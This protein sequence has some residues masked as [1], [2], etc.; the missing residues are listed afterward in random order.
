MNMADVSQ[1]RP[2]FEQDYYQTYYRNYHRQ[3][4]ARKLQHYRRAVEGALPGREEIKVLDVGC[5]FGKFLGALDERW[6]RYGIDVS[7]YAIERAK[8]AVPGVQFTNVRD[9]EIPFQQLFDAITAWDVIEHISDLDRVARQIGDRLAEDG[10][11][12][13]VVPVYDG[14]LGHAVRY[15]DRDPTHVH[16]VSRQFWLDWASRHFRVEDWWGVFRYL[17][18]G[19]HYLHWPTRR[20]RGVAP[21]V[22]VIARRRTEI[23]AS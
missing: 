6:H 1:Q 23:Q 18:P 7:E 20:L 5:A 12:L 17:L 2:A 3:N 10:A 9:G 8:R 21:A 13:F 4:P 22:A 14:P 16:R 15:L 19:G 11:F